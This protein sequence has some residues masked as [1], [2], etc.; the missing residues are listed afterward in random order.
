[1]MSARRTIGRWTVAWIGGAAIGVANGIARDATYGRRVSQNAARQTS[2]MTGI[3]VFAAYF[4]ALQRRWPLAERRDG[5]RVGGI[6]LALT[7]LFE[8]TF[9]RLVAKK[10][11][12]ELLADYNLARG[13]LWPLVLLWIWTGPEIT[14]LTRK[15]S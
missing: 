4:Q 1:M 15:R 9:G 11:W 2:V 3:A 12:R 14:R 8:F 6:W 10:P 13:R 5:I 7:V